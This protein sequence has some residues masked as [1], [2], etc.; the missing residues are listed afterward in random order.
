[1]DIVL[2]TEVEMTLQ[3]LKGETSKLGKRLSFGV[4]HAIRNLKLIL[5]S[6]FKPC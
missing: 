3:P 6:L 1:M 4:D 2:K 5:F